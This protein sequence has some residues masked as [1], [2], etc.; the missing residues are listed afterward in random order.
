MSKKRINRRSVKSQNQLSLDFSSSNTDAE[1]SKAAIDI[2]NISRKKTKGLV[3]ALRSH[4][5]S[6][7]EIYR[8]ILNRGGY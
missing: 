2:T 1:N 7:S 6:H 5:L 8:S 3:I 4:D